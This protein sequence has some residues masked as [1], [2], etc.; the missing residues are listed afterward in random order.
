MVVVGVVGVQMWP[1]GR[2]FVIPNGHCVKGFENYYQERK[3]NMHGSNCHIIDN[4]YYEFY[5]FAMLC[6]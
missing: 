1:M 2:I 5:K 6:L 4:D 3:Y